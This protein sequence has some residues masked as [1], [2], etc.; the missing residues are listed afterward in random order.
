AQ[1]QPAPAKPQAPSAVE[2]CPPAFNQPPLDSPLL[3]RCMSLVA[4]P[5]NETTID[6]NTYQYYIKKPQNDTQNKKILPYDAESI[7]ADF[8]RLW[9]TNFLDNL[10][11]EVLDEPFDNGVKAKHVIFHI[12]ERPRLK[13]V[14]Y[15]AKE[16]TKTTVDIS[17]I[18]DT[19]RDQNIH[20]NLDTF[21]D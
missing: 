17:K 20:V 13:A 3:F 19:L 1:S 12:E 16:G 21:V 8:Y 18:E 4:H 5:I 7:Q 9:G 10:W 14:D 15:L 6:G 2:P 11:I